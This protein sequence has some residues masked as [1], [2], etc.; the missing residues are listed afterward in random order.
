MTGMYEG[1]SLISGNRIQ[2]EEGTLEMKFDV[3]KLSEYVKHLITDS[4]CEALLN[5]KC[6]FSRESVEIYYSAGKFIR[7][8]EILMSGMADPAAVLQMCRSFLEAVDICRDYLLTLEDL[9]FGDGCIY[10]SHDFSTVKFLYMPGRHNRM[11]LR[12]KLADI[13]DTAIEYSDDEDRKIIFLS[14]YKNRLYA[15][16]DDLLTLMAATEEMLRR[17]LSEKKHSQSSD[18]QDEEYQE[19]PSQT[20]SLSVMKEEEKHYEEK[21]RLGRKLK[22]IFN[23][24]V[25]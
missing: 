15:G 25:S 8:E 1:T 9:D 11:G 2:G 10:T 12:E 23:E 22:N 7:M 19:N 5:M 6:V 14:E 21:P 17:N 20:T 16:R 24:L 13:V 3:S 4:R 18:D